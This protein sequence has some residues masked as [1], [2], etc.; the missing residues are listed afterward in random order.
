MKPK[1]EIINHYDVTT[2]YDS[3]THPSSHQQ[4]LSW[5]WSH[6]QNHLQQQSKFHFYRY[7]HNIHH[8]KNIRELNSLIGP[9]LEDI[10]ISLLCSRGNHQN[11]HIN[12]S[13]N[14]FFILSRIKSLLLISSKLSQYNIHVNLVALFNCFILNPTNSRPAHHF[15]Q[16]FVLILLSNHLEV[17]FVANF[18][19]FFFIHF[20]TVETRMIAQRFKN[21]HIEKRKSEKMKTIETWKIKVQ[22]TITLKQYTN[23]THRFVIII[24][25]KKLWEKQVPVFIK[26]P[27]IYRKRKAIPILPIN[28]LLLKAGVG[29]LLGTAG[30]MNF[31]ILHAGRTRTILT[32]KFNIKSLPSQKTLARN[33]TKISG[34]AF[35][36][37]IPE[38]HGHAEDAKKFYDFGMFVICWLIIRIFEN[39]R[40]VYCF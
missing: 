24:I 27:E 5:H 12:L 3:N 38:T 26:R 8:R 2:H 28:N 17:S 19:Q 31:I 33:Q 1:H 18:K 32:R 14:P 6:N 36:K 7:I 9:S 37:K 10:S 30:R 40:G 23:I 22:H 11:H 20:N 25:Y 39:F 21:T 34:G 15:S 4:S 13:S 35:W 16:Q 29:N